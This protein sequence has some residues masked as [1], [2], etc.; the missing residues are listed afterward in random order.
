VEQAG[1]LADFN[2]VSV[3][4]PHV[5]ADLCSAVDRRRDERCP[6]QRDLVSRMVEIKEGDQ[7][8]TERDQ[9]IR[10]GLVGVLLGCQDELAG[11]DGAYA[12]TVEVEGPLGVELVEPARR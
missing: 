5:A 8:V 2:E 9:L 12:A 3:R 7:G 6:P 10:G 11:V 4:V 1:G